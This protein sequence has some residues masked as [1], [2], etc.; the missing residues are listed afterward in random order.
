M[1]HA[2][3][4][5]QYRDLRKIFSDH[6]CARNGRCLAAIYTRISE[7]REGLELGVARQKAD[8]SAHAEALGVPVARTFT[9]DDISASTRTNKPR[10]DFD[11]MIEGIR[12]GQW[13]VIIS[14][15]NS[16]ITRRP[17][18]LEDL[19]KLYET[20][21]VLISTVRSGRDDLS[22][23]DGRMTARIKAAVDA[24]ESERTAERVKRAAKQRREA[25]LLHGGARTFG[26]VHPTEE[27]R[28]GYCQVLDRRAAKAA[29]DAAKMIL[30]ERATL[31]D[32][33]REWN[34]RGITT[35]HGKP[36]L[37]PGDIGRTLTAP[38]LAGL[39]A[40]Q[41]A[42]VGK[43]TWTAIFD[44]ATH[45]ALVDKLQ[46]KRDHK[47]KTSR[48]YLLPGFIYCICGTPMVAQVSNC[49]RPSNRYICVRARGG[50]GK[51]SRNR[52]WTET[53]VKAYVEGRIGVEFEAEDAVI[54][55][56]DA[57]LEAEISD[58]EAEIARLR[59]AYDAGVFT[60][61][62]IS[63][64]VIPKRAHIKQLTA[65][66]HKATQQVRQVNLGADRLLEL[67]RSS[68]LST[69]PDRRAILGDYINRVVVLPLPER[70]RWGMTDPVPVDSI[71]IIGR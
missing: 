10:P 66:L 63:E 52:P 18:E 44:E 1:S 11:L 39:V 3:Q 37:H 5:D 57:G 6:R 16:R 48:R 64:K 22:T 36:W 25:G 21:G 59:D 61:E 17:L 65:E 70:R 32:I 56:P 19:I 42:V 58:L 35:V 33:Q 9:D 4:G 41:G 15:S 46:P 2:G 23:A 12:T 43:G 7:D 14:Y 26:Y 68:D 30:D 49:P 54:N 27:N 29:L 13:C 60:L 38:R 71:E 24:A 20:T 55:S 62:E 34:K 69:L 31:T 40:H 8:C 45:Y 28:Y 47:G 67:W 51:V 53:M 50:C